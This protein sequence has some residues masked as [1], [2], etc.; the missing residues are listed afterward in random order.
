MYKL[1]LVLGNK[2]H[3]KQNS[4]YK[5]LVKYAARYRG[6]VSWSMEFIKEA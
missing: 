6:R 1:I 4:D 3:E 5:Y 2:Y